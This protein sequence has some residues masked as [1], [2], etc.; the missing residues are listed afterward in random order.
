VNVSCD[1]DGY[2]QTALV[3]RTPLG[4]DEKTSVEIDCT[5]KRL[6]DVLEQFA[7]RRLPIKLRYE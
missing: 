6:N 5:L 4:V 3:R 1:K 7:G 2:R